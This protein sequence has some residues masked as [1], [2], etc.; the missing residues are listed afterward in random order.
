MSGGVELAI[1][2]ADGGS[3]ESELFLPRSAGSAGPHAGVL[4]LHESFGLNDDI[5]RIAARFADEGYTAL[6]PNLFSHG[7][8]IVCLSR[9]MTDM[10]RGSIDPRAPRSRSGPM[11]MPIGSPSP[12]SASAAASR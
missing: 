12:A 10:V 2:L 11:S 3:L 9:V 1:S 8:R 7:L 4:V 5:R 6:V